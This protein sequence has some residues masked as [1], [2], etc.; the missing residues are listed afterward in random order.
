MT[1][2][3]VAHGIPAFAVR[4]GTEGRSLVYSGDTEPCAD[5]TRLAGGGDALL[6]EAESAQAP[7][8]GEQ[9][10]HTPED[11]GTHRMGR[12]VS[13]RAGVDTET[14]AGFR[15]GLLGGPQSKAPLRISRWRPRCRSGHGSR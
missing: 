7:A 15:S 10:H 3:A 11:A 9:A 14:G 4:I 8:Q 6:C 1:S 12:T 13:G 2:R 5:L